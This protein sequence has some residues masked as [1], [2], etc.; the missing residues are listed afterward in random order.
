[1]LF[2]SLAAQFLEDSEGA[3]NSSHSVPTPAPGGGPSPSPTH[4]SSSAPDAV[5]SGEPQISDDDSCMDGF[6]PIVNV[7]VDIDQQFSESDQLP[8]VYEFFD[9]RRK[10]KRCVHPCSRGLY[11]CTNR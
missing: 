10:L 9:E 1:M 5:H 7:G 2:R 8:T 3:A 6:L 11:D 4:D